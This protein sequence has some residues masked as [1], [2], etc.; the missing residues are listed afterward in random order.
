MSGPVAHLQEIR[1]R[2]WEIFGEL[3]LE[4][5]SQAWTRDLV[6]AVKPFSEVWAGRLET[7]G[8]VAGGEDR[9]ARGYLRDR[10]ASAKNLRPTR[11]MKVTP[12][13]DRAIYFHAVR[14]HRLEKLFDEIGDG[15]VATPTR[16]AWKKAFAKKPAAKAARALASSEAIE[17]WLRGFLVDGKP[18]VV[19]TQAAARK[20]LYPKV[21][22]PAILRPLHKKIKAE[23]TKIPPQ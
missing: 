16:A 8:L 2:G 20:H 11:K 17:K 3:G 14:L 10:G 4:S 15:T 1:T 21:V 22:L 12:T 7:I 23:Q 9:F 6:A 19:K 13:A 18:N 5:A